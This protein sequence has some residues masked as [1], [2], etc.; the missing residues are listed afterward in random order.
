MDEF[1]EILLTGSLPD[2]E[3]MQVNTSH[4]TIIISRSVPTFQ[5]S[6]FSLVT[7]QAR[8]RISGGGGGGGAGQGNDPVG[9]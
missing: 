7:F 9:V 5:M 6:L 1:L 4:I 3:S 8:M 2:K